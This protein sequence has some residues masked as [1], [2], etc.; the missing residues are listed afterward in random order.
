M[1]DIKKDWKAVVVRKRAQKDALLPSQW[2]ISEHELPSEQVYDVTNICSEKG[3]LSPEKLDVTGK[4]VTEL[5]KTIEA[6][7][8]S[9]LAVVS[10]FAH[11]ATIAQQLLN[12]YVPLSVMMNTFC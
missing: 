4:T 9:A 11:R 3:W 5:A 10:A 8:V 7:K 6:G 2:L 12:W 1:S